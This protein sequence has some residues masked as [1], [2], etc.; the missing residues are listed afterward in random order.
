MAAMRF[1]SFVDA[2]KAAEEGR[3]FDAVKGQTQ[4]FVRTETDEDVV[5]EVLV[6]EEGNLLLVTKEALSDIRS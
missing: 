3:M 2:V 5:A 6:T 4:V 1:K